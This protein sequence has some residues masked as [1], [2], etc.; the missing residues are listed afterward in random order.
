LSDPSATLDVSSQ[1]AIQQL[2]NRFNLAF[3]EGDAEAVADLFVDGGTVVSGD[4]VRDR[5]A[6]KAWVHDAEAREAHR[7]FTTNVFIEPVPGDSARATAQA[8]FLYVTFDD[9][10]P[11]IQS[12]GMYSD[13]L[14]EQDGRWLFLRR[15]NLR[16]EPKQ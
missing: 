10:G 16:T 9:R 8:C 11:A 13:E 6:I 3:D 1:L 4:K 5:E 14:V 12:F 2:L 15:T 7:H